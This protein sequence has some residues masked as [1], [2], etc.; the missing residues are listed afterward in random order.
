MIVAESQHLDRCPGYWN[1]LS[2]DKVEMK[3]FSSPVCRR[4]AETFAL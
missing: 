1:V 2:L 3:A 4:T